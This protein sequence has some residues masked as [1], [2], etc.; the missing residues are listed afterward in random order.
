MVEKLFTMF[1]DEV[2]VKGF[3]KRINVS[4]VEMCFVW[5]NANHRL[6]SEIMK[7]LKWMLFK[8]WNVVEGDIVVEEHCTNTDALSMLTK[9][10]MVLKYSGNDPEMSDE[11]VMNVGGIR[12]EV[13]SRGS[14]DSVDLKGK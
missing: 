9:S 6:S 12:A 1:E 7:R 11:E 3:I 13:K 14:L 10:F 2:A 4:A 8:G 5:I